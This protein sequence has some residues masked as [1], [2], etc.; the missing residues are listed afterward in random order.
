MVHIA[1]LTS[2]IEQVP[3]QKFREALKLW[4]NGYESRLSSYAKTLGYEDIQL[5]G[6]PGKTR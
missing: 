2:I 1:Q 4:I 3:S 5:S 6:S